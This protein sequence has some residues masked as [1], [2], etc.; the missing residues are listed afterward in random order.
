VPVCWCAGVPVCRCDVEGMREDEGERKRGCGGGVSK[1]STFFCA[2]S[3]VCECAGV[4]VCRCAGVP[5]CRCAGVP[6]CR[7]AGVPVCWCAG[8]PV[9]R[10]AGVPV[11][12]CV[13]VPVCKCAGV[14][15]FRRCAG[16]PKKLKNYAVN[17]ITSWDECYHSIQLLY[18]TMVLLLS[19]SPTTAVFR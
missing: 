4:P 9:C 7:C 11:C 8:V 18:Y 13:S 14:P 5:V 2:F 19:F 6:V 16:V 1:R 10:C 17:Y 15:V 12:R 3:P